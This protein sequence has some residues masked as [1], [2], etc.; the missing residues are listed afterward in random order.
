MVQQLIDWTPRSRFL[1]R[2]RIHVQPE[3]CG[4]QNFYDLIIGVKR[5]GINML[6]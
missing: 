5:S 3:L 2:R 4:V 1:R 6:A